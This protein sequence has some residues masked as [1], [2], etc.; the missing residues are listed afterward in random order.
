[1]GFNDAIRTVTC[2]VNATHGGNSLTY[3]QSG[4]LKELTLDRNAEG[5]FFGVSVTQKLNVKLLNKNNNI[6]LAAGD[7]LE[8]WMYC[9]ND[10]KKLGSFYITEIHK[11]ENTNELSITAYDFIYFLQNYTLNDLGSGFTSIYAINT[12]LKNTFNE[13]TNIYVQADDSTAFNYIYSGD[14]IINFEGT[15]N[16]RDILT[17]ICEATQT[18]AYI[19]GKSLYY[20]RLL[21]DDEEVATID[22]S[23]YFTLST[24]ENRRLVGIVATTELG[25]NVGFEDNV[26]GTV[27]Y[28]NENGFLNLM[29][30]TELASRINAAYEMLNGLTINQFEMN[31]RGNPTISYG[32]KLKIEDKQGNYVY[33]YLLDDTIKYNGAYSQTT[34]WAYA[35]SQTTEYND[36][37]IGDV[38]NRT[39]ARVNKVD[40]RIDML[41]EDLAGAQAAISVMPEQIST[42]VSSAV[43]GAIDEYDEGIQGQINGLDDKYLSQSYTEMIQN[44][45]GWA[46][47]V[48]K[49]FTEKDTLEKSIQTTTVLIN[50]DGIT[51]GKNTS[52][53][54]TNLNENGMLIK[55]GNTTELTVN[56]QGVEAHNLTAD[57]YLIIDG[58]IRF[59][60]YG[61]NRIGCYW[62]GGS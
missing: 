36:S 21:P 28:I 8:P 39:Y 54:T 62:I 55:D 57:N 17:Q 56:S 51:V 43:S 7:L 37:S 38:L 35:D 15:E 48:N 13:I 45:Y 26:S 11:D 59:Q 9:G 53:L 18:I 46:L 29:T 6:P 5:K 50:E 49:E 1:M 19:Y 23:K 41:A 22:K 14:N 52:S 33:S 32:S 16:L 31:W 30:S 12:A 20:I 27:Q 44:A 61:S 2:L 60:K 40:N 42:T 34:K 10:A 3:T 4:E 47:D 58:L 25:D 24:K